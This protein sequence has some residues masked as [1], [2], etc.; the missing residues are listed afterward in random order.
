M[1]RF[2]V[3]DGFLGYTL[4]MKAFISMSLIL[5][6]ERGGAQVYYSGIKPGRAEIIKSD[7]QIVLR[8]NTIDFSIDYGDNLQQLKITNRE[9]LE[10]FE[11]GQNNLFSFVLTSKDS[12]PANDFNLMAVYSQKGKDKN[13]SYVEA[14][15]VFSN[16]TYDITFDLNIKLN[17][18]ANY[19]TQT[20]D[21]NAGSRIVNKIYALKIPQ[22]YKPEVIGKVDGA[23]VVAE[24]LFY[25]IENPMFQVQKG[26]QS[27][28]LVILPVTE[29]VYGENYCKESMSIGC[30]PEGQLR[31][32]FLYYMEKV[33]ANP[34]QQLTFYDSWYDLSYDL[35]VL[36]EED[37]I[38]RVTTWGDSL[39]TRGTGLGCFLWDSGWDDWYNMWEFNKNLS[40]GFRN[41]NT[42]AQRY[43]ASS[44]AW[45]S[46]WGG[47]DEFIKIRLATAEKSFPQ[48][49]INEHGFTLT[50][51]NYYKYFKDVIF[52]LIRE[53]STTLFK[54]DGIDP[55]KHNPECKG[56]GSYADEMHAYIRL[57][58]QIRTLK[59]NVRLNLT[60]GTWPSPMWLCY[61]DNVWR[62]GDD[63]GILGDGNKR[64]Q[65]MNYRDYWVY[66]CL[67]RSPLCPINSIMFHGITIANYGATAGYEME[68]NFIADDIWTFFS[69][70]TSLQEMYINPHRL[71]SNSWDELAKAMKWSRKHQDV[72]VDSH[73]V[74]G[75]PSQ[76]EIYGFAS[77]NPEDGTLML[78]NPSSKTSEITVV[79][80][81]F[82][83]IPKEYSGKYYIYDVRRNKDLGVLDSSEEKKINL[84]PFEVIVLEIQRNN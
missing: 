79:L 68:D 40:H 7:N 80:D 15:M 10:I 59:P 22:K 75:D 65:W 1:K 77:W 73:W 44:G 13:G 64:Q 26:E 48:Y 2:I 58:K 62:G 9:T 67:E 25:T 72:L 34:Y 43:N 31:R 56:F 76:N 82:L 38:N 57:L 14:K 24:H 47:Y 37:C 29:N 20:F 35:N 27:F 39:K 49:E 55:G 12:I 71:N 16:I 61:G 81:E 78:R 32:G 42:V 21:V 70:G 19:V 60:V 33:R 5:F 83:E 41:I 3:N 30:F 23:P 74:G 46:P 50:D 28:D 17:D 84:L 6:F 51:P 69:N 18:D 4:L 63:Y 53:N 36:T 45:L 66:K 11:F 54:L 8:N 52:R